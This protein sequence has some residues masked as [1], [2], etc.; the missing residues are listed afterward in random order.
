MLAS[1][2][3][4][5]ELNF[6]QPGG[7]RAFKTLSAGDLFLFKLHSPNN[8][9]VGGGVF[10]HSTLL[11][12]RI[13]WESFGRANGAR[14]LQEMK[15]RIGHYRRDRRDEKNPQIGCILLTQPFFLPERSW[16]PIPTDW[17]PNIVQGK[18][19]DSTVEPGRELYRKLLVA[20]STISL[21]DASESLLRDLPDESEG[22]YGAPVLVTPR[23]GQG[24][25]R[26][27]VTDAYERRCAVTGERVLPVLEAAH[28][29]PY[30]EMG[31]HRVDNGLLLRS[32]LHTLFDQREPDRCARS[33]GLRLARGARRCSSCRTRAP[34]CHAPPQSS[35][36]DHPG[37][38]S[39]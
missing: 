25:F 11:P 31:P 38:S 23:L 12:L 13:A 19:Y 14:S 39:G 1:E 2:P 21:A 33:C 29:R 36:R 15:E 16:I 22:R 3:N 6:W 4:V 5:E 20:L 37:A 10:A 18:T 30:V 32:D 9:V 27:L 8:F 17:S 26:V 24:T 7:S 35:G 28:I 34:A